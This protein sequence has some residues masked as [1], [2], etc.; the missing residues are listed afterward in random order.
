VYNT[1][2]YSVFGFCPSSGILK[3]TVFWKLD[4][5]LFSEERVGGTYS[6]GSVKIA[7]LNPVIE[8]SSF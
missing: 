2:N 7:N 5:F 1:Q 6:V 8:L 4:L 3:N